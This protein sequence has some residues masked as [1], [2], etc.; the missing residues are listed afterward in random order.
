MAGRGRVLV[1]RRGLFDQRG[2]DGQPVEAERLIGDEVR[3]RVG[4][5]RRSVGHRLKDTDSRLRVIRAGGFV[6]LLHK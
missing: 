6:L 3:R 4:S 5:D 2:I 1:E